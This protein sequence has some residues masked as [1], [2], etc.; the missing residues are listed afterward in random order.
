[1]D[2][3]VSHCEKKISSLF[4]RTGG[5]GDVHHTSSETT[6]IVNGNDSNGLVERLA[7]LE[8]LMANLRD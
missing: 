3:R 2:E 8:Q 1:L 6:V 7:A 5:G 4:S